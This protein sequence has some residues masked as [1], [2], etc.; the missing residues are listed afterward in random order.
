M[1]QLLTYW[2]TQ[3]GLLTDQVALIRQ[4]PSRRVVHDARVALKKMKAL[5]KLANEFSPDHVRFSLPP[6]LQLIFGA[7]GRYRETEMSL[8]LLRSVHRK[9]AILLPSFI[10]EQKA[11]LAINRKNLRLSVEADIEAPLKEIS[12][13]LQEMD[14]IADHDL[15]ESI[16]RLSSEGVTEL[17]DRM[18]GFP[19]E[20]HAFRKKCKQL[21]YWLQIC[22][23]NTLYDP[24]EMKVLH[25]ALDALGQWHDTE[26]LRKRIRLFRKTCLVKGMEE[27]DACR[28]AEELLK[29]KMEEW[30]CNAR[31]KLELLLHAK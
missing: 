14:H 21:Y 25:K 11:R 24:A 27:E 7:A 13:W 4:R 23:L 16:N 8:L 18:K 6:S 29:I 15:N 22:T 19:K 2:Q 12:G 5:L 30:L 3:S 26:V 31:E 10:K 1:N 28:K 20:A 17:K 9:D